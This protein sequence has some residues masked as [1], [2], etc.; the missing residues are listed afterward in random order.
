M[1]D[2]W[3]SIIKSPFYKATC[4]KEA[5]GSVFASASRPIE[6]SH[7]TS[8]RK[9]TEHEKHKRCIKTYESGQRVL[10][11]GTLGSM[12]SYD[13]PPPVEASGT[14]VTVRTAYGD[15]TMHN[16]MVFVKWDTGQFGAYSPIHLYSS[17]MKQASNT[18]LK[19]ASLGDL[20]GY[21][22]SSS[23]EGELV[24]KATKDIW[25]FKESDDGYVIEK[26]FDDSG[27]PLKI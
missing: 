1:S 26:L 13:N 8:M 19:V 25:S 12:L 27:E 18:K 22:A 14:I 16:G 6:G 4:G 7:Y 2:F 11:A 5:S 15:T 20:S 10:F 24:H 3:N 21:F 9:L 23:K 17:K